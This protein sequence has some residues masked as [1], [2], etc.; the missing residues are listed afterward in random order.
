[1]KK[2]YQSILS[3]IEEIAEHFDDTMIEYSMHNMR[4]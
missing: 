1:M 2:E 3:E 4:A